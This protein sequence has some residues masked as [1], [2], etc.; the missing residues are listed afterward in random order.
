MLRSKEFAT[1]TPWAN[2]FQWGLGIGAAGFKSELEEQKVGEPL[3]GA[4]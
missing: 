2:Q 1:R 3:C 4:L